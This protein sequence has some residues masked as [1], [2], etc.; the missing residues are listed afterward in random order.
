MKLKNMC[1]IPTTGNRRP[2]SV[3]KLISKKQKK[4][5]IQHKKNTN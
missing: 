1:V 2:D 3:L 4:I 5:E